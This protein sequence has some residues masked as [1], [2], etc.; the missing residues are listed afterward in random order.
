MREQ[1]LNTAAYHAGVINSKR[2]A[3]EQDWLQGKLPFV[4]CTSAFGM[5]IDKSDCRWV[6]HYNTPELLSEYLQEIGRAGRDGKLAT[7]LSLVS[8]PTGLLDSG[9]KQ[10]SHFFTNQLLR[11]IKQAKKVFEIL[12]ER[13]N[14]L[15]V[16]KEIPNSEIAL[17]ILQN[18]GSIAWQDPFNYHKKSIS[19]KLTGYQISNQTKLMQQFFQ[20]KQCRWQFILSAFG[21]LKE[22]K[23]FRCGKCDRCLKR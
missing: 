10:R 2:R 20:T 7:A 5:G 11:Q 12:P 4:I 19:Q 13:G 23:D 15:E 22:A 21:F 3:T 9:D 17:G 6:I 1:G 14:I 16:T 8:E 18:L